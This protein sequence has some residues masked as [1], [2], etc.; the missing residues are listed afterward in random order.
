[1]GILN[2]LMF[3]KNEDDFDFDDLAKKEMGTGAPVQDN[4]GLDQKP[5]GLDEKSM[6]QDEPAEQQESPLG[7]QPAAP[8]FGQ[9]ATAPQQPAMAQPAMVQ[10]VAPAPATGLKDMDLI[11]SKLDTLKAILNSVDQRLANIEKSTSG[12]QKKQSLW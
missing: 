5:S 3:W 10:P 6:F 8:S 11:N 1:M 4:L 12:D 7:Q 9:S 2:K